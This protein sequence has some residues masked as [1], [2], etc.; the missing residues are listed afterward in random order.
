MKIPSTDVF[1]ITPKDPNWH[2][3]LGHPSNGYID[4]IMKTNKLSGTYTKSRDCEICQNVKIK[5]FPHSNSL[6]KARS[7]FYKIHMDTLQVTPINRKGQ[8]YVLVLV[9]DYSRFN[10]IY[11]MDKK[12][13][14]ETCIEAYLNKIKHKLNII[15]AFLHTD[16]GGE[17]SSKTFLSNLKSKGICREQGPPDS[18]QT[19]GVAKR[20]NQMLLTKMRC[21]LGQLN[22]PIKY[23]DEAA[24]HAS[25]LLNHLPHR[26]LDM[27]TPCNVL[28]KENCNIEPI[29][30]IDRFIPFG[31]KVLVK[32]QRTEAKLDEAGE[33][34]RA[35]TF[36]KYSDRLRLLD[37]RSGGIRIPRDYSV[38]T[39]QIKIELRNPEI[40]LPKESS[41]ILKLTLPKHQ[42]ITTTSIQ[43]K[44][45]QEDP[46]EDQ[47]VQGESE[48]ITTPLSSQMKVANKHYDYVPFYKKPPKNI[49]SSVSDNNLVEVKQTRQAPDCFYLIDIVPYSRALSTPTEKN[50]WKTAMDTEF[51]SLMSHNTGTLVPYP[52]HKEKVIGGMWLLTHKQNEFGEVY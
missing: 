18:L 11:M 33:T 1:S 36:E 30:N 37:P 10:R 9:D 49:S 51:D 35:L 44:V 41:Q 12:S 7:P 16:S 17:F 39:K 48:E 27:D 15:P 4:H 28:L 47:V 19:N 31:M 22:I 23:W 43:D 40:I 6:P 13:D 2:L 42:S 8:Q 14:A 32:K 45:G 46:A 5:N 38:S 29:I 20:F 52:K 25:V 24:N 21:L 3:T 50:H 34:L 26:S